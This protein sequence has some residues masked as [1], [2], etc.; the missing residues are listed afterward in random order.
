MKQIA[1]GPDGSPESMQI[2]EAAR[3]SPGPGEI[4]IEVHF[5]GVNGPDL[6]Q[7][8]GRYPPPPG[9]SPVLGLE[10]A[11]SVAEVGPGVTEWKVGD[12]VTALVPGGGY[13]DYCLTSERHALPIPKA[14]TLAQ[15]AGLPETSFTV[16]ANLI[17][18]AELQAGE[19][20]LIH[21]GSSGIGLT[22][23]GLARL[24]GA[25]PIVTVG[26]PD[27]AKFCLEFGAEAAIDYRQDDFVARLKDI[28]HGE[29]VDV[30]LDMVG[31]DYLRR[32]ISVLKRDGRLV[33]IAFQ[34]GSKT[35]FDF[36]P[37]MI[38]RLTITGS[39]MRP[40]TVE[41]KG[42]IRDALLREVW[43]AYADGR[44]KTHVFGVYPIEN[45]AEAH[46]IMESRE[47]IGKLIL[48]VRR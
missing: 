26:S 45:A 27:K 6:L 7:R 35:E 29:G 22:A 8:Q 14:M 2:V 36:M 24:A 15:A 10:V 44:L 16:W 43:P 46:R 4:L 23:I 39:T 33:L 37:V 25:V 13:A 19:R 34:Q 31:G 21:G 20:A 41:E 9:A 28:T 32:D 12:W 48:Q 30:V 17:D 1:Y 5:A 18:R 38:K 11:G 3:P 47:H 42:R 40:R